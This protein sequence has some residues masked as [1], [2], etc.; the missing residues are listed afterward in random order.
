[1]EQAAKKVKIDE[2]DELEKKLE[3][4]EAELLELDAKLN[5]AKQELK[6]YLKENKSE[7]LDSYAQVLNE[8]V[9]DAREAVKH[10]RSSIAF[11]QES[12]RLSLEASEVDQQKQQQQQQQ[13]VKPYHLLLKER[14]EAEDDAWSPRMTHDNGAPRHIIQNRHSFAMGSRAAEF[15]PRPS[16]SEP[17]AHGPGEIPLFYTY[18]WADDSVRRLPDYYKFPQASLSLAWALWWLGDPAKKITPIR[19]VQPLDLYNSNQRKR[20]SDWRFAMRILED[21]AREAGADCPTS[22]DLMSSVPSENKVNTWFQ[23]AV[24]GLH[25]YAATETSTRRKRHLAELRVTTLVKEL[26]EKA[27]EEKNAHHT[28]MQA[29]HPGM[30]GKPVDKKEEVHPVEE[31][32]LTPHAHPGHPEAPPADAHE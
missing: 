7:G 14:L 27:K 31:A 19:N 2:V 13:Q 17:V 30:Q 5:E 20:L 15:L 1:M 22:A 18:R 24:R 12:I 8:H 10:G 6:D 3:R 25:R 16:V 26:R 28:N 21:L 9:I 29:Q 11:L 4:R 23:E 32:H